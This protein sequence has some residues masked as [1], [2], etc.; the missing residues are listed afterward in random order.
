MIR[1]VQ[2]LGIGSLTGATPAALQNA[3]LDTSR[4]ATSTRLPYL[5]GHDGL[6]LEGKLNKIVRAFEL[7]MTPQD[8]QPSLPIK[9][10]AVG[11]LW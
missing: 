7:R 6:G 1:L 10:C 2:C 3:L 4:R 9:R 5:R 11:G 8:L